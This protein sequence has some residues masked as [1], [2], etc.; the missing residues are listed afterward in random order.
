MAE[1]AEMFYLEEGRHSEPKV[2]QE[3]I[4]QIGTIVIGV[5][6]VRSKP[7]KHPKDSYFMGQLPTGQIDK[8]LILQNVSNTFK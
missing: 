4:S 8:K 7:L 6:R 1:V 5:E 2:P 3:Q